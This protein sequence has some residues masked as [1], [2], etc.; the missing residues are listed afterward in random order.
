MTPESKSSWAVV[1]PRVVPAEY[2]FGT[3]CTPSNRCKGR[4]VWGGGGGAGRS[5]GGQPPGPLAFGQLLRVSRLPH[6][7]PDAVA[8]NDAIRHWL[9]V[10]IGNLLGPAVMHLKQEAGNAPDFNQVDITASGS[11]GLSPSTP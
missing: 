10:P 1:I 8:M 7:I 3:H 4:A 6:Q 2:A 9:H 11:F 5:S